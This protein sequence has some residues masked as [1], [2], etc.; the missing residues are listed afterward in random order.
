MYLKSSSIFKKSLI[1][2]AAMMLAFQA[3]AQDASGKM[4]GTEILLIVVISLVLLV[5]I[6]LLIS[7]TYLVKVVRLIIFEQQKK[8]AEE[9][10]VEMGEEPQSWWQKL[11]HSLTDTVPLEKEETVM[12]DHN[13]DGIRELD[14]HLPPWWKWLFY[15]TIAWAFVYFF[16]Y[17]VFGLFPLSQEEYDN[18]MV[19]ARVAMEAQMKLAGNVIDENTVE[20][21]D[22]VALL[23]KGKAIYDRDCMPCHAPQGQGLIGP[24]FT[25]DYWIHGGSIK[26][27]FIII[28]N[29]VPLKGMISWQSKL[30]PADMRNV[31]SYII[32]LRGTDPP[33]QKE[34]QGDLYVPEEDKQDQNAEQPTDSTKVVLN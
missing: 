13:Y 1:S 33:N 23:E 16:V 30:S 14:N 34:P 18:E 22:D 2:L 9:A 20:F 32:T 3:G 19:A 24:N 29:G 4:S 12:L 27:M 31:A 10:G 6:L 15:F 11:M 21:T 26:D 25:D 7:I 17:H 8:A 28:K 5:A